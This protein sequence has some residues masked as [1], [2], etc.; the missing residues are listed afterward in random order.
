ML[1]L[2]IN[3]KQVNVISCTASEV[4][5]TGFKALLYDIVALSPSFYKDWSRGEIQAEVK[6]EQVE[7]LMADPI[8]IS[9]DK[10]CFEASGRTSID[11]TDIA[12][13]IKYITAT[14]KSGRIYRIEN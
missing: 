10:Y 5:P 8:K 12:G 7:E 14:Y 3:G 4:R 11:V 2:E 1:S 6:P 9:S 13:G